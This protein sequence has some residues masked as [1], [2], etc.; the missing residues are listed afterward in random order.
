LIRQYFPE[1]TDRSGCTQPEPSQGSVPFDSALANDYRRLIEFNKDDLI[2][3]NGTLAMSP[4][5]RVVIAVPKEE[6]HLNRMDLTNWIQSHSSC[7]KV[8][9]GEK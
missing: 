1:R 4:Q 9:Q 2:D 6:F 7:E 5:D 3:I 8:Y